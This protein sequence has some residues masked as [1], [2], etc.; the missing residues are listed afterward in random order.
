[1]L[2]K[3]LV[4][5]QLGIFA[6][7]KENTLIYVDF[8]AR[9]WRELTRTSFPSTAR[10]SGFGLTV[11]QS[12]PYV[13][14]VVHSQHPWN[15]VTEDFE[16]DRE[17]LPSIHRDSVTPHHTSDLEGESLISPFVSLKL[18]ESD[19]ILIVGRV[20]SVYTRLRT[21]DMPEGRTGTRVYPDLFTSTPFGMI[22]FART[23]LLSSYT[24]PECRVFLSVEGK[25]I[26]A[27][28]FDSRVYVLTSEGRIETFRV[29][30]ILDRLDCE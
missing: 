3:V 2:K 24:Q 6:L 15:E 16:I 30:D 19:S 20:D 7:S 12:G 14:S 11:S 5:A 23:L 4:D 29:E 26:G 21:E 27:K 8:D 13:L 10:I 9:Q 1:M 25:I 22:L 17:D 18:V 28:V